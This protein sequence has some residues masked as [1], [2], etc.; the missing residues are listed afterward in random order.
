M[1]ISGHAIK[2]RGCLRD[3]ERRVGMTSMKANYMW[4]WLIRHSCKQLLTCKSEKQHRMIQ[5]NIAPWIPCTVTRL[6][7]IITQ[8]NTARAGL[9]FSILLLHVKIKFTVF[10]R[11]SVHCSA[12]LPHP[13]HYLS[14]KMKRQGVGLGILQRQIVYWDHLDWLQDLASAQLWSWS[15]ILTEDRGRKSRLW[16]VRK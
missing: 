12:A 4:M 1:V 11:G 6:S 9:P 7:L 2:Q 5:M 15:V 10:M 13:M 16:K 8:R 3:W 14:V